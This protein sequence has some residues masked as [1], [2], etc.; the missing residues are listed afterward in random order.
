MG[1]NFL[2]LNV[3]LMGAMCGAGVSGLSYGEVSRAVKE[4]SP[5][6][7]QDANMKVLALGAEAISGGR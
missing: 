7:F 3:L 4:L 1:G 2:F 5:P 6:K